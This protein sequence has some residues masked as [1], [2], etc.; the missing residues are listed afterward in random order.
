[1]KLQEVNLIRLVAISSIVLWHC[2]CCP[3]H[4]WHILEPSLITRSVCLFSS[5]FIPGANMPLFACLSGYLF[6]YLYLNK[7]K[8]YTSFPALLKTKFHRLFVPFL[9]LGSIGTIIVADRPNSGILWGDGS[10]M[11]FC[12]MLFWLTLFRWCVKQSRFL[13]TKIIILIGCIAFYLHFRNYG[14]PHWVNGYPFGILCL[15]RA[16]YYYPFFCFG[17]YL[18]VHRDK[19]F[20]SKYNIYAYIVIFLIVGILQLT[21]NHYV[22]YM[23]MKIMPLCLILL[24]FNICIIIV[25]KDWYK[26]VLGGGELFLC[27]RFWNL[28]Y[29]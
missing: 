26:K 5:F 27:S 4:E 28:R 8:N 29:A 13:L 16:F 6:A 11:W 3:I 15:P 14:I 25:N 22:S 2:F 18:Y 7:K 19:Y 1:M 20:N 12:I 17:E 10:S 21:P 23:M 9:V 24:T